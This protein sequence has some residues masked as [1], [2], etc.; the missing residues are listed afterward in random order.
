MFDHVT[1]RVSD[2][3]ASER[4]YDTVLGFAAASHEQVDRF[5]RNN[6]ALVNHHR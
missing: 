5:W 2:R 1:I 4:F 3:E 6:V